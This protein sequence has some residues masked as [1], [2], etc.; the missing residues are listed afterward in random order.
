ML[1]LEDIVRCVD[2]L[3]DR[4]ERIEKAIQEKT[5]GFWI[6]GGRPCPLQHGHSGPHETTFPEQ[7]R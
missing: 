4:V 2:K 1:T 3:L 7:A 5:C 6:P